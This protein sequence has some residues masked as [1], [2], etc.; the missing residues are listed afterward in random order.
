MTGITESQSSKVSS[1]RSNF[2]GLFYAYSQIGISRFIRR[3]TKRLKEIYWKD[4]NAI[5]E[6]N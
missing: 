2:Q 3:G 5:T 4:K 6:C 1:G